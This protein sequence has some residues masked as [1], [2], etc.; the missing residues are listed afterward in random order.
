MIWG[1]ALGREFVLSFFF[2]ANWQLNFFFFWLVEL[3]FFSPERV[4]VDFF[5]TTFARAPPQIIN[6]SS[7]TSTEKYRYEVNQQE[8]L[9]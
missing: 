3:S 2:L 8:T 7:L 4:A 6:G 5:F 9:G 1:G